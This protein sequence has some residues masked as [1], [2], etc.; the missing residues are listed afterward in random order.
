[1]NKPRILAVDAGG[2]MTDTFVVDERG[3]FCVGKAQTTPQDESVGLIKSF[4]DALKMWRL[5]KEDAFPSL[6]LC[7]YSG[8]TMLNKLLSRQGESPIGVLTTAGFEDTLRFGRGVQSYVNY[9]YSE[10]LH[11][12]SHHHEAPLVERKFIKG[13]RERTHFLGMEMI[14]LYENDVKLA[15]NYFIKHHVKAICV[16]LLYSYRNPSHELAVE[17]IV[18]EILKQHQLDG[19]VPVYLSCKHSPIRGELPRLNTLI[20][21]AYAAKPCRDGLLKI[22]EKLRSENCHAPLR[23]LTSYGGTLSPQ[24]KNLVSTLV[25]GPIG[26]LI[27][28]R[29]L[30][31]KL[32]IKNLVC[33][34]VGG[35]SFD[36]GLL[37][38]GNYPIKTEPSI[39]KFL[40]NIPTLALDSKGAGTGTY[41]RID[42]VAKRVN[43][44]PDSAGYRVGVSYKEGGADTPTITDCALLLGY[45]NPD[46][47]LGGEIK[48]FLE[49]AYHAVKTKIADE[50]GVDVYEAAWGI[51]KLLETQMRDYLYAQILGLGY[52][53]ENYTLLSY[54]GGGPLHVA[55]YT[56]GLHFEDIL[57]PSWAAAF[58]AFGGA[59]ADFS[60]RFD[61]SVDLILAP[62]GSTDELVASY[63]TQSFN[64]IKSHLHDEFARSGIDAAA[65]R[66]VPS[67]RMQYRGMLD[68][69]EVQ[70]PADSLTPQHLKT[71]VRDFNQL[72]ERMYARASKSEEQ[73]YVITKAIG[74]CVYPAEKPALKKEPLQKAHPPA[75]A[76]KG[77]REIYW[78]GTWRTADVYE[79]DSLFAG[80][81]I[82]GP[83]I[84]E[85]PSTTLL[86]PP[87]YEVFL[88]ELRIF[89]LKK[90]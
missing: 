88:D 36:V 15:V 78:D 21:E 44:G 60:I 84:M 80:N 61:E 2:T 58:S 47:F 35:T 20:I 13:V 11:A 90:N 74:S 14:P 65:L 87:H 34:D 53:P 31:G 42:P 16:C 25:S 73:G 50:L 4:Q 12:I 89:H 68:D 26:G 70:S 76:L 1:M 17:A 85:A 56:D 43:L 45:L 62:D 39:E 79:I 82:K 64:K 8:T 7:L 52:G 32:G 33:T 69:L 77:K 9:P 49:R 23:V 51:I 75:A 5:K 30:G 86:L 57:I 59:C 46:Y 63:L 10:R 6:S 83:A 71:L 67:V 41:I 48:L 28:A 18:D 54:G 81:K 22:Q 66:F 29:F 3:N 19:A 72:F 38:D 55:G 37:T 27:G 40:L 24:Q